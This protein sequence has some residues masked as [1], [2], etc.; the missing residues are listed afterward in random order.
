[1][2]EKADFHNAPQIFFCAAFLIF[3]RVAF[4]K[5]AQMLGEKSGL[6]Q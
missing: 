2:V 6:G 4:L 5:A 1:M 3:G